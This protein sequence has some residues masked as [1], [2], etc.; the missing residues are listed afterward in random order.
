MA[1]PN[2]H[3][4]GKTALGV[5]IS[6]IIEHCIKDSQC[7]NTE[8]LCIVAKERVWNINV[9]IQVLNHE[10]NIV[11]TCTLAT[12][13]ALMYF[14][15]P[16]VTVNDTS[17]TIHSE[18]EKNFIP[19]Q[20]GCIPITTSFD[21]FTQRS[22]KNADNLYTSSV[23]DPSLLEDSVADGLMTIAVTPNQDILCVHATGGDG[24][25]PSLVISN[26]QLAIERATTIYPKLKLQLDQ[27]IAKKA[28]KI[29]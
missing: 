28:H 8:V 14:R 17:V 19:L 10:G 25:S 5:E 18:A 7:V 26:I 11:D 1:S 21:L 12:I 2:F 24:Y 15:R 16:E 13:A 6:R 23:L 4:N 22:S 27:A 29:W 20:L 3:P 9:N